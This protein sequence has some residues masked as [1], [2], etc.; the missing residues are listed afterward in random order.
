MRDGGCGS[1]R[2]HKQAMYEEERAPGLPT[3]LTIDQVRRL[4][5]MNDFLSARVP[6]G[7]KR[8]E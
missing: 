1:V 7:L 5:S 2:P 6:F 8:D 3:P 4:R